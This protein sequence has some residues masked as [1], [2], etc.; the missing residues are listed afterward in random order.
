MNTAMNECST[1]GTTNLP[2]EINCTKCH[3]KLSSAA[4]FSNLHNVPVKKMGFNLVVICFAAVAFLF[5]LLGNQKDKNTAGLQ[6]SNALY[7]NNKGTLVFKSKSNDR[8]L[9]GMLTRRNNQST[10]HTIDFDARS[11]KMEVVSAPGKMN[12]FV[13]PIVKT[14]EKMNEF[15]HTTTLVINS[16]DLKEV[17][18]NSYKPYVVYQYT[19]ASRLAFNDIDRSAR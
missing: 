5:T 1:C 10:V 2:A 19:D 17:W 14:I 16:K 12:A 9:D 13:Y 4:N 6:Q 11:L 15:G 8:E 7:G 18:I 3:S